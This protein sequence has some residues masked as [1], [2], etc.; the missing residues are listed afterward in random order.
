MVGTGKSA[1]PTLTIPAIY[2]RPNS[3][4]IS[5]SFNST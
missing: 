5:D 3:F 1:L 4:S 2:L